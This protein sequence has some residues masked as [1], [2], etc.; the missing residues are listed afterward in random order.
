MPQA[1]RAFWR[2]LGGVRAGGALGGIRSNHPG[3][4]TQRSAITQTHH[5]SATPKT[6]PNNY[7]HGARPQTDKP[8]NTHDNQYNGVQEPNHTTRTRANIRL[9]TLQT[10]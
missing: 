7:R 10:T 4:N 2:C 1:K 3:A 5:H 9:E 6:H 8:N